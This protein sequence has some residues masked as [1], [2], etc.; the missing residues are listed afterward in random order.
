MNLPHIFDDII[1]FLIFFIQEIGY[2]GVFVG[3]FIESTPFPLPSEVIMIPVGIAAAYNLSEMNVVAVV[4]IGVLGNLCGAIFAYMIAVS[5][6]RKSL[7]KLGKYFFVS[8][9]VINKMEKFFADH[10]AISIFV[11]RLLPGFRH[12]I[13]FAAGTARMNMGLF[14]IYTIIGS[15]FWTSTLVILGYVIG[16]NEE[17]IKQY[18]NLIVLC[19]VI[20]CT[21]IVSIYWLYHKRKSR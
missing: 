11:S 21:L 8:E 19:C 18:L 17:L 13:S 9:K 4:I 12:L 20:F 7:I 3:M 16:M 5:F 15:S 14:S 1:H 6:G 2:I 10:G